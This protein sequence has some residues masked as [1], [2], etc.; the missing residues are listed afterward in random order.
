[1]AGLVGEVPIDDWRWLLSINLMGVIHGCHVFVPRL[2]RQGGGHILNVASAAGLVSAPGMA[3]YNVSKAGVVALSETLYAELRHQGVGVTVLCPTFFSTNIG[4]RAGG[5]DARPRGL[6]D[7][8]LH[9]GRMSAEDVAQ[10]ALEGAEDGQLYVVPMA[11]GRWL[12]RAK[13]MA[14]QRFQQMARRLIEVQAR[15]LGFAFRL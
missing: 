3:P 15:R 13:R 6:L 8:L 4:K 7:A 9:S 14:P 5:V 1:V 11:D 12:W 2:K 10:A